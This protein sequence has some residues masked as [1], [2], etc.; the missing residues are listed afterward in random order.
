MSFKTL[1]FIP[2]LIIGLSLQSCSSDDDGNNAEVNPDR[3][4]QVEKTDG[5]FFED[6]EIITFNEIG[7][8]DPRDD[9]GVLRYFIKNTGSSPINVKI[10]VE[11]IRGTDGSLFTFCVQPLCIFSVSEGVSYPNNGTTINPG[12][13]NSEDD[14]F[15]NND[16]GNENT[17]SIEYDLRF[18]VEHE[19]GSQTDDL[20]ITYQYVPN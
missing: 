17:T 6:G 14:Y 20:T 18:Y 7:S 19:D 13:L 5:S 8:G 10:E 1:L 4:L 12:Q 16:P 9:N 2:I 15:I 11:S 3:S